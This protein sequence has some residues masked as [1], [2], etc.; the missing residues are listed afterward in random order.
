MCDKDCMDQN[1]LAQSSSVPVSGCR[2][3]DSLKVFQGQNKKAYSSG[4]FQS[5]GEESVPSLCR[6]NHAF[7][8]GTDGAFAE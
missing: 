4:V 7:M 1:L 8:S 2:I 5:S 6:D 3:T